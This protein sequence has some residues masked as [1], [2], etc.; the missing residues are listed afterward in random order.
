MRDNFMASPCIGWCKKNEDEIC[1]G[2]G[3]SGDEI[4]DWYLA[5]DARKKEIIKIAEKRLISL[6]P[7]PEFL[8]EK[9]L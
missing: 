1:E 5:N 8:K 9:R 3:R 4:A 6:Q 7:S 2:C